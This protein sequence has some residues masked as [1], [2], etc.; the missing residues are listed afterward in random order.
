MQIYV[1]ET[2][3]AERLEELCDLALQGD[4]VLITQNGEAVAK[5]MPFDEKVDEA[6]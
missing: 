1:T 3:A 6:A 2:E 4:D 5:L